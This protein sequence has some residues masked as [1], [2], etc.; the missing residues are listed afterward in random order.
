MATF[1]LNS[2]LY[3][4]RLPV[5]LFF[6]VIVGGNL[7]RMSCL[8]VST[9]RGSVERMAGGHARFLRIADAPAFR[10]PKGEGRL[11]V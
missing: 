9:S 5:T 8:R 1:A 11:S 6:L 7:I 3:F 10:S 2:W 4:F